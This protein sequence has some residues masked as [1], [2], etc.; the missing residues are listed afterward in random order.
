MTKLLNNYEFSAFGKILVN[1]ASSQMLSNFLRIVSGLLVVRM[2]NPEEYG[3]FTG[4]GVY[5]GYFSLGHVGIINGLGREFPF[6]LGKGNEEYGKQLANST[7]V[8]TSII[9][10]ITSLFFFV[11]AIYN[12][13]S[14]KTIL[15][16][17]FLSYVF[18]GGLNLFYTQFFPSLYRT[19]SDF[20]KLSKINLSF[21]IWNLVSV[22]LVW[23]SGFWGLIIRAVFLAIIQSYMLFKKKPYKLHFKFLKEDLVHLFKT[24]FPIFMV[25][26]INPIWG[27]IMNTIIFSMGGAK[28]FGL[29]ALANIVQSSMMVIPSSFS[30]VIYPRMSIMYGEGKKAQDI[31]KLNLKPMFLQFFVMLIISIIGAFLLPIVIPWL[32]PKYVS[33]IGAAQLSMFLPVVLSFGSISDIFNVTKQQKF[34]FIALVTG[35]IVGTSYIFFRLINAEFDLMIF[36]QGLILGML[37]QQIIAIFFAL[38]LK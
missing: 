18:I 24:G 16:I 1:F 9:G 30:Q 32:L 21:G 8:V 7:Y 11:L 3:L 5:L 26:Q 2:L 35:A 14:G 29:Y 4:I 38:R 25:G 15:G 31:I 36:P 19:N 12:L 27:T 22:G 28:F 6:H 17:I 37:I 20:A 13:F 23:L 10:V 33:G 34:Y